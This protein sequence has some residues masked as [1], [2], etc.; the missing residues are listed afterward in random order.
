[1]SRHCIIAFDGRFEREVSANK[2]LFVFP[3]MIYVLLNARACFHYSV[4]CDIISAGTRGTASKPSGSAGGS[5]IRA[6]LYG[7]VRASPL[8]VYAVVAVAVAVDKF[9]EQ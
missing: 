2:Y 4:P 7:R 5:A 6:R 3:F 8:V 1:M 9:N